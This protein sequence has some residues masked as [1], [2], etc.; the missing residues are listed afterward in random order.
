MLKFMDF[1]ISFEVLHSSF[2]ILRFP[3]EVLCELSGI[4]RLSLYF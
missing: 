3:F 1:F 2:G 4:C